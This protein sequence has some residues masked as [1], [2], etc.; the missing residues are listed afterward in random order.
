MTEAVRL[1]QGV[2]LG[3]A[4]AFSWG[5]YNV[6]AEIGQASGFRPPDLT[7]LRYGVAALLLLPVLWLERRNLPP[8]RQIALVTLL[9]GPPFALL[10]NLGFQ[11]APLSHAV[12]IGPGASMLMAN[13]LVWWRYHQPLGFN[14]KLG[15]AVLVAGLL[16]IAADQPAPKA[17]GGYVLVG[18]LCFIG[19]G[20]L[21]GIYVYVMGRWRL[22]PVRT[23][24]AVAAL[25]SVLF[26]PVYLV[27]WGVPDMPARLW[28]E[29]AFYQGA[30]GGCLAFVVF[31]AAVG[32][33]GAGRA[34]LF[35]ALVPSSA[36]LL[37]IPMTGQWPGPLEWAGVVLASAGLMISL[38]LRRPKTS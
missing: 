27:V 18:D 1:R 22:P 33:L 3:I 35:A 25:A 15:I 23:T 37:A 36:V 2:A 32:R 13:F 7:V 31:A 10:F 19:S 11:R 12:V 14:R 30:I 21:W 17:S 34:A 5:F 20:S 24:A 9:I 8:F 6:G 16:V 29:Q 26:V 4:A 28:A 38:D